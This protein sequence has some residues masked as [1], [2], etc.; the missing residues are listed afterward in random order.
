MTTRTNYIVGNWKMNQSL[1]DIKDF[2]GVLKSEKFKANCETWISPQSLHLPFCLE[3][4][5]NTSFKIGSQNICTDSSGAFTGEVSSKAVKELGCHFTLIGHSERRSIYQETYQDQN[6]KVYQAL[7]QNL[8][9][10]FCI[11]E[12]LEEREQGKTM[13]I[14]KEQIVSSLKGIEGLNPKNFVFAYEPVWA[15]G[16]GKTAGPDQAEEAHK[17]IRTI[18]SNELGLPGEQF[19]ILYGGSVKPANVQDLMSQENIDGALVGGASLKS[20]DYRELCAA[21]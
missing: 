19:S 1:K 5:N 21:F 10:I 14:L 4:S 20:N 7:E 8:A 18:I 3:M 13:E 12:T 6:K 17:E 9:T 16:T 15:I 11:G 2:F